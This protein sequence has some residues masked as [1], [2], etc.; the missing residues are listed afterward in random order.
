LSPTAEES[1]STQS[2]QSSHVVIWPLT[3]RLLKL[4]GFLQA[5]GRWHILDGQPGTLI[6]VPLGSLWAAVWDR[7]C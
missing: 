3:E 5:V 6:L 2:A 7:S 1:F 4:V